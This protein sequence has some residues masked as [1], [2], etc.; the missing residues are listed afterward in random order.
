MR[1]SGRERKAA[2]ALPGRGIRVR[3]LTVLLLTVVLAAALLCWP[4]R[5]AAAHSVLTEAVPAPNSTVAAAPERIRLTFNER[6]EK[7]LYSITVIDEKGAKVITPPAVMSQDQRQISVELPKLA[8]GLYTVS[9]HIISADGHPVAESY[10]LT[11]GKPTGTTEAVELGHK[12]L[13]T[14]YS[15]RMLHYFFFLMLLGWLWWKPYVPLQSDEDAAM[16]YGR[17]LRY[18]RH[19]NALFVLE[20]IALQTIDAVGDITWS[21][22]SDLWFRTSAGWSWLALAA[23]SL[24]AYIITGR[25]RAM[26]AAWIAAALVAKAL[27]G[28]PLAASPVWSAVVPDVLHLAAGTLWAGG[29]GIVAV[30]YRRHPEAVR[31][32]L[33]RFSRAAL[34]SVAVLA[35]TGSLLVFRYVPKLTDLVFTGWGLWLLAKLGLV[36]LVVATGAKLRRMMRRREDD[37]RL[38]AWLQA[39]IA[40][41]LA[42]V[43]V[44]GIFTYLSPTPQNAPLNWKTQEPGV[45]RTVSITPNVPGAA[46]NQFAVYITQDNA[47][48]AVKLVQMKLKPL[49]H[50]E[51]APIEV[52]LE[53]VETDA[54]KVRPG[55]SLTAFLTE[56][57]YLP[58]PG[59]WRV[60]LTVRDANDDERVWTQDMRIF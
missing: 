51:V 9:Y 41:M 20:T 33:P 56:G 3:A 10:V 49:S 60:E 7:E 21:N 11:I 1:T 19:L 27:A 31:A 30:L 24:A 45:A 34:Y 28:H 16:R 29:L 54:R 4:G 38:H 6:L 25:N 43:G 42:I 18:W 17:W 50:P 48:P 55:A 5:E 37:R 40:L 57:P 36:A 12:H 15:F 46:P 58:F 14:V 35:V 23:V 32:F 26:E 13:E 39:D 53:R 52:P 44:V 59:K 8:D 22:I 47:K 2:Y